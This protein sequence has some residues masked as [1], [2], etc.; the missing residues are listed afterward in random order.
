MVVDT[1]FSPEEALRRIHGIVTHIYTH[2]KEHM[3]H[4]VFKRVEDDANILEDEH[5]LDTLLAK[6]DDASMKQLY[7]DAATL[8]RLAKENPA[9][10]P[11]IIEALKKIE[12]LLSKMRELQKAEIRKAHFLGRIA[13]HLASEVKGMKK[14]AENA[15]R[16]IDE[17]LNSF[18]E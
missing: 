2:M 7:S 13:N 3:S 12:E 17:H 11:Q 10:I 1:K 8:G 9:Y 18:R 4:D 6:F 5:R 16:K 14:D 15:M